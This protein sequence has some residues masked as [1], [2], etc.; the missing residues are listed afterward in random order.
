MAQRNPTVTATDATTAG[1][2]E[3]SS[4]SAVDLSAAINALNQAAQAL[5]TTATQMMQMML[6]VTSGP[7][8]GQP[9]LGGGVPATQINTLED[10]PFSEAA[11]TQNPPLATPLLVTAPVNANP[12]LQT[13]IL[14]PQPA[15]GQFPPGTPN[16]RFWMVTEAL[17]RGI[18][19]WTPLLPAGTRWS[20]VNPM[21]V[22]LDAGEDL[23]AFYSRGDPR[24]NDGLFFFHQAV[25]NRTFFSADS[26]D[27]VI[28]ELGHAI[29]DALKP[30]LFDAAS[31]QVAA[32]HEAFG[33]MSSILCALQL[34]SER[35]KVLTETQG[36]LNVTSRLSRLAEQ[37]GW[38]IRQLAPTAV[39]PD[40]LRNAANRFFFRR[41]SQLPPQAPA[42]QLSS[43]VH[44]FSRVFTGAFL[45]ALAGMLQVLGPATEANLLT[46]SR[47]LGQLLVDGVH[48]ASVTSAY[49]SQV[50]AAMIQADQARNQG[51]YRTALSNAFRERGILSIAATA[52]LAS[53]PVPQREVAPAGMVTMAGFPGVGG[54]SGQA[55]GTQTRLTYNGQEDDGYRRGPEDAP[56]LPTQTIATDFGMTLLVPAPAEPPR[57]SVVPAALR[58]VSAEPSTPDEAARAFVEDLIQLDRL[59]LRAVY[60]RVSP[61]LIAPPDERSRSRKTHEVREMPEGPVLK[62]LH[63]DCGIHP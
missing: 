49:Y 19:F 47:A 17:A 4:P 12:L 10:D 32:F 27:V 45:D 38:A 14:D 43:E 22:T 61:E 59:D 55:S 33:D 60:G 3:L 44:S 13:H 46:A 23:N 62:R 63:F 40:C 20:V 52:A 51:R 39:D 58:G 8:V 50:A 9:P 18:N 37:L 25:K 5:T 15:S 34:P 31:A 54:F 7:S 26:P 53:A 30:Q 29:L 57:F 42:S 56:A 11:P 6:T 35:Q 36:R 48:T 2:E 21:H 1:S 16:F 24:G 41:P 28:H